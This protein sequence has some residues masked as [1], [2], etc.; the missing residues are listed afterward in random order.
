M[1]SSRFHIPG[2]VYEIKITES[3]LSLNIL[4]MC[5]HKNVDFPMSLIMC[6]IS[7]LSQLSFPC[8]KRDMVYV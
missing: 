8:I 5:E 4:Q 7:L 6:I 3:H 2:V 1:T